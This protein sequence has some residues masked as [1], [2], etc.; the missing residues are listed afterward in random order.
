M[1][2]QCLIQS[3]VKETRQKSRGRKKIIVAVLSPHLEGE[4]E[5]EWM[6]IKEKILFPS[7]F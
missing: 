7:L 5:I 6:E 1:P 2:N 4:N 3:L